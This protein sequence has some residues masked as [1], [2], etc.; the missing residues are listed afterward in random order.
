MITLDAIITV[1][2]GG[3]ATAGTNN[4][5]ISKLRRR[6]VGRGKSNK[7]KNRRRFLYNKSILADNVVFNFS[8]HNLTVNE[9]RVL[10][11]GLGFVPSHIKPRFDEIDKDLKR[12]ERKLQLHYFFSDDDGNNDRLIKPV[13]ESNASWWP[14]ILNGHI[15][16][17]CYKLKRH[18]FDALKNKCRQNLSHKELSALR[19]LKLNRDIVI[20]KCDKGGGI[21]VMDYDFY[22]S[23]V[24]TML[25]DP[26][27][28]CNTNLNDAEVIKARSDEL[29]FELGDKGFLKRKQVKYLTN[30]D[31]RCPIFY[32]LPKVHKTNVPLRPIVSQ[33]NG[34]TC[35]INELV[36]K[37]LYVAEKHIPLLLQD[38]TA[39]LQL[40]DKHKKC[41]P[42]TIL[43]TLDVSSLYTNIPHKEGTEWVCD[44][45]EETLLYWHELG[46]DL[47]PVDKHTLAELI[48]FILDNCTFEFNGEYY[49]QNFG[50]TMGARFSVKFA[51]IYMYMW[52]RRFLS[53][54]NGIKPDFIARLIDD[55]F[56]MWTDSESSLNSF[57]LYLNNCHHSIKFEWQFSTDRVTFLDTVTYI[58]DNE[59]KTTIYT[60]PTDRKQYLYF[61]S[62]HPS[63]IFKSIPYSQALR[64]RR[65]IEDDNLL[66]KELVNL[67]NKFL[68]RGYPD[69]LLDVQFNKI[70]D[71][72]RSALLKYKTADDKKSKFD[73]FLKGNSFLP[74]IITYHRSLSSEMFRNTLIEEWHSFTSANSDISHVFSNEL[75][76]IVFKRGKTLAN[77][78]TSTKMLSKVD[79]QDQETIAILQSLLDENDNSP[80]FCVDQC[81]LSRCK[82]CE[83]ILTGSVYSDSTGTKSFIVKQN[84]DCSSTDVIYLIKCE[85]CKVL[86]VG[87]T[88]RKLKDRLNNHRS[89]IRLNKNTAVAKHFNE[90]GH[91]LAHL[92][93]MPIASIAHLPIDSRLKIEKS[94]MNTLNT[95]YPKG[96]NYYPL[97]Y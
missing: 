30:F 67:K 49:K 29:I 34:P 32:G 8:K 69:E 83:H 39:Y 19:T 65:I 17:F 91:S 73:S 56:F 55:C 48:M 59:L 74:L 64:Y 16:D 47:K 7:R 52:F 14:P 12:F 40:I 89:D 63:H 60:K 18:C 51:N 24:M 13:L 25:N 96:L 61:T 66:A 58:E 95:R 2:F 21:A 38:T 28:Y 68:N 94:Y 57:L 90:P 37:Y 75:P 42:G 35:K 72:E 23:R 22:H 53:T 88:A 92:K 6:L 82:C 36:D 3:A 5:S 31:V 62:N 20:K 80:E 86:Y 71:L 46:M 11:K 9:I 26:I 79:D 43:V 45:Y 93:I 87:Q 50:T 1:P 81:R 84:F 33:I 78:L 70:V 85:F 76:Q 41:A 54:Y 4:T 77:I 15:T 44:F 10:N 97:I 27:T